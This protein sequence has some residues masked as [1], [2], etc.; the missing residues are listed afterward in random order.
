MFSTAYVWY[1]A[2]RH[3]ALNIDSVSLLS[4]GSLLEL[5]AA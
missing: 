1:V 2:N 5:P 3:H 4:T